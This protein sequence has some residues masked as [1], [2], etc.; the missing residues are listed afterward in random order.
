MVL[1]RCPFLEPSASADSLQ[2]TNRHAAKA[3]RL[4]RL[5]LGDH[6]KRHGIQT[7][8]HQADYE[9]S[10]LKPLARHKKDFSIVQG[11]GTILRR[12]SCGQYLVALRCE[13]ICSTGAEHAQL[14]FSRP[15]RRRATGDA[16][17]FILTPTQRWRTRLGIWLG[18]GLSMAWDQNES[19]SRA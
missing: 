6:L 10:T 16:H 1:S 7:S 18:P 2:S 19:R 5:W 3:P 14:G 17:P 11:L 9:L 13:Q 4:S 8:K 12:R 15:G